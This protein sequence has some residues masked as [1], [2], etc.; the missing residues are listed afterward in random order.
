MTQATTLQTLMQGTLPGNTQHKNFRR[1]K[2]W[3]PQELQT[4]FIYKDITLPTNYYPSLLKCLSQ[5]RTP[6]NPALTQ[7]T[8]PLKRDPHFT[9][10]NFISLIGASPNIKPPNTTL[11]SYISWLLCFTHSLFALQTSSIP[12]HK[13]L[14][15]SSGYAKP[16]GHILAPEALHIPNHVPTLDQSTVT[17]FQI[18]TPR[19]LIWLNHAV[20]YIANV[21]R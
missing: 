4:S 14:A 16:R 3:I 20:L 1:P 11:L 19:L 15:T 12:N 6:H 13:V 5:V 21:L 18:R 7:P 8:S 2:H 17:P 10:G 9:K